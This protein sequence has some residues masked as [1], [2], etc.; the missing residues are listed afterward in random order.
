MP[1]YNGGFIGTDG[2]DAPD[3][4]SIDSVSAGDAQISV[5][6]TAGTAGTTATSETQGPISIT[7]D[8]KGRVTAK[9][10]SAKKLSSIEIADADASGNTEAFSHVT[11]Q[12]IYVSTSAPNSDSIGNNGDIWYQ[13]LT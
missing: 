4:P 7:T 1:R 6:F 13:T 9:S 5:A 8:A 3:A 11:G 10:T 12:R 2:L